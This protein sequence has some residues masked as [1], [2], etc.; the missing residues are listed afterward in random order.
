MASQPL[1]PSA[2][3]SKRSS[4]SRRART[5]N[6]TTG[7][8]STTITRT[9]RSGALLL[10]GAWPIAS[11][12]RHGGCMARHG[13]AGTKCRDGEPC[14]VLRSLRRRRVTIAAVS[15]AG[16]VLAGLC[17]PALAGSRTAPRHNAETMPW[18]HVEHPAGALP[19]IQDEGGRT[20]VLR[21]VN[22]SGFE[23]DWY[24]T[25]DGTQHVAPFWPEDPAAFDG[26]CPTNSHL[27]T[28][29]ALCEVDAGKPQF[30][31][32]SAPG[33]RND[34]A[35]MRSLGWNV[36]RLTINWSA[37]EPTPGH[38][39]G[40]YLDR[41][42]QVVRWAAEQHIYV[43]LDMHEDNYSRFIPLDTS[44]AAEPLVGPTPEGGNHAD[45]APP[46]AIL[47]DGEPSS[48][49]FGQPPFNALVEAAFTSFWA[50]RTA[51]VPQGD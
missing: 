20:V 23:D 31:Q 16:A 25:A 10:A 24:R 32:S 11:T 29:P 7:E 2:T 47:T 30:A 34:F 36:V 42:A 26:T 40:V 45:G 46:W 13:Q 14:E 22:A 44:V 5:E 49:L 35:Q 19:V 27:I 43:L 8:S 1:A 17:S 12:L 38:Y 33:S 37:L 51:P 50:N 41:M 6:L 9:R 21:G 48:G 39:D 3:T 28:E 18:L 4:V 15:A